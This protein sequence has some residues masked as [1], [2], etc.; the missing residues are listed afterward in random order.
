VL[1]GLS[2]EEA[3]AALHDGYMKVLRFSANLFSEWNS[4]AEI[5][6][7]VYFFEDLYRVRGWRETGAFPSDDNDHDAIIPMNNYQAILSQYFNGITRELLMT[8][9]AMWLLPGRDALGYYHGR[10]SENIDAKI[11]SYNQEGMSLTID[12]F[13]YTDI[14]INDEDSALN[15]RYLSC[16]RSA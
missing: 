9:A 8:D 1:T 14:G 4:P 16:E 5:H 3:H 2:E 6:N 7:L 11:V 13:I 15:Y 10:G 12:Y